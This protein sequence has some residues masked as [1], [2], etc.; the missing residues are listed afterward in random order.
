MEI[1]SIEQDFASG[2][3]LP[4]LE[5][6]QGSGIVSNDQVWLEVLQGLDVAFCVG[7]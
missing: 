4:L 3:S 5:D 6:R 1:F 2:C 7:H